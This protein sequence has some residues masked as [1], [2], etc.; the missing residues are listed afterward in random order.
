MNG[1]E[2]RYARK[3]LVAHTMAHSSFSQFVKFCSC[4]EN[5]LEM[6]AIGCS[7]VF[8]IC[9]STAPIA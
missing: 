8:S 4:S 1:M 5:V 6:K 7:L 2:R 9:E 3:Y